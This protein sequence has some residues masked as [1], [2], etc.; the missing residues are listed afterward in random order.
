MGI[1]KVAATKSG[2]TSF[3]VPIS[4]LAGVES[5]LSCSSALPH[6]KII[7]LS[8]SRNQSPSRAIAHRLRGFGSIFGVRATELTPILLD[9]SIVIVRVVVA[10]AEAI[11]VNG[12]FVTD[13]GT[14]C[15]FHVPVGKR[16][17]AAVGA[18][19]VVWLR[20]GCPSGGF[21]DPI[22]H[23]HISASLAAPFAR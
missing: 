1:A 17:V 12:G 13:A 21:V 11:G 16:H 7:S 22:R 3:I 5:R 6:N 2:S 15:P 19:I 9:D 10:F 20:F 23:D 8:Q 18:V 14:R 4:S